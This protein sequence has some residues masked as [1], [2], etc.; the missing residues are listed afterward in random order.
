MRS[1]LIL[2]HSHSFIHSFIQS[3]SQSISQSVSQSINQSVSRK[4]EVSQSLQVVWTFNPNSK[5]PILI[6]IDCSKVAHLDHLSKF[7]VNFMKAKDLHKMLSASDRKKT[8]PLAKFIW[9]LLVTCRYTLVVGDSQVSLY[10]KSHIIFCLHILVY[11]LLNP[12]RVE[13]WS[14]WFMPFCFASPC[15]A[16]SQTGDIR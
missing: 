3:V 8:P 6:H 1:Q 9:G 14:C 7:Q 11:A 13:D 16:S 15:F 10:N 5:T 4:S 12:L 2:T